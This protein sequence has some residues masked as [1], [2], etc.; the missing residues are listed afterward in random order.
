VDLLKA[1][2]VHL[3]SRSMIVPINQLVNEVDRRD[4][5]KT[6]RA[7]G[8][9]EIGLKGGLEHLQFEILKKKIKIQRMLCSI[10]CN[11]FTVEQNMLY[12]IGT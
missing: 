10:V 7:R 11:F 2:T 4:Q 6:C 1:S 9:L 12:F 8:V 5:S 3:L